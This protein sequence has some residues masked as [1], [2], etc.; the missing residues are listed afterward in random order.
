MT[1][2]M[3]KRGEKVK[4]EDMEKNVN[5]N[6]FSPIRALEMQET[7][8]KRI[9]MELHDRTVQDLTML[10]HKV[11]LITKLID[12]DL[13]RAKLELG[14]MSQAM[15]HSINELREI[16]Y[17]LRPMSIDDLGLVMT[18]ERHVKQIEL[19]TENLEIE[20]DVVNKESKDILPIINLT[21]FRVIQEAL[22]NIRKH[23]NATH[24][25]IQIIYE[26]DNITVVIIDNGIGFD[27]NK[28]KNRT[29]SFG[30]SIMNERVSLLSGT[31]LFESYKGKGTTITIKVPAIKEE[32][33]DTN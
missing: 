6:S 18:I 10:V 3:G 13:I 31:I 7:D 24:V 9:S 19:E 22:N 30:L 16:I 5:N 12:I 1:L 27:I 33:N 21:L 23:A 4:T 11:E 20:I 2:T 25:I 29:K 26:P 8:R 15:R 14:T 32:R 28:M 17:D